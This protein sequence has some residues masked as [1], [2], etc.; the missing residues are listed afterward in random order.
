MAKD[1][2]KRLELKEKADFGV[3]VKDL[4]SFVCKCVKEIEHVMT[5]GNQNRAVGATNMNEHSSRSHAIFIIT[6]ESS[7]IG[8]DGRSHIRVGKLNLVDLAGSERQDKTGNVTGSERQKEGIK[9]NLSLSALG[10]VISALVDRKSTHIPYRDSK[11][12]RL[13]EDSLGGNSKT[14]MVANVGPASY[15]YEESLTTLRYANRA[16]R[17]KNKPRV[18][19]DP[20]DALL[21]EFQLEIQRLKQV[22]IDKQ[23]KKEE[24]MNESSVEFEA[25][26]KLDSKIKAMESKLLTGGKNILDHTNEQQRELDRRR[27]EVAAQKQREREILQQLELKEENELEITGKF[28]SKQQEIDIK[29]KKLRKLYTKYLLIKEEIR[30]AAESNQREQ[31]ELEDLQTDLIKDVKLKYLIIDNFIPSEDKR[32]LLNRMVYDEE[33][34]DWKLMKISRTKGTDY[35]MSSRPVSDPKNHRPVCEYSKIAATVGPAFRYRAEDILDIELIMPVRST[36]DYHAPLIS[37]QIRAVLDSAMR[38]EEEVSIDASALERYSLNS[39]ELIN[40]F[41]N[42]I[43]RLY[44]QATVAKLG[45]LFAFTEKSLEMTTFCFLHKFDASWP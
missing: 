15:N 27:E 38:T 36:K 30:D 45:T 12:T 4:S 31:K 37:P 33:V 13:L 25:F 35:F 26:T 19:E 11:L 1:Q 18:N 32:K 41:L 14:V 16:K 44:V 7:I 2:N 20:K 24:I 39:N 23:K 6:V 40:L 10:H 29:K 43:K 8:M 17:I 3:Y 21:R 42:Q 28:T 34:Q 22:L 9:I 5:V